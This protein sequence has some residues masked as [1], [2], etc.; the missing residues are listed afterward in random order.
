ML[1]QAC[2][3]IRERT[4]QSIKRMSICD[5]ACAPV[6]STPLVEYGLQMQ[7]E[8]ENVTVPLPPAEDLAW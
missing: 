2:H 6:D 8:F 7:S 4:T 5:V 3:P 1:L